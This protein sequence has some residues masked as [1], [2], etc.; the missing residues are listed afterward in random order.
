MPNKLETFSGMQ[1]GEVTLPNRLV[2]APV[3]TAFASPTGEVV[4]KHLAY[5]RR[6]AEGGV[7][8]IIV[9]PM[10]IDPLGKEHPKQLGIAS[11]KHIDGLKELVASIH[12]GGAVAIA[13]LNHGGRAANPKAIGCEAEAPSDVICPS[14]GVKPGVMS[15]ERIKEL[16]QVFAGAVERAVEAGFDIVEIQFGLGYLISQFISPQTNKRQDEYGGV[17][18]N[19]LR[20]GKEVLESVFN[21]PG[22][23]VPIIA[24]ISATV[25]GNPVELE[26]AIQL[27]KWLE[28]SGVSALHVASGSV[29]DSP[30]WYFQHMRLPGGKNLEW[31]AQIKENVS[32]PVIVAGRMGDPTLIRESLGNGLIDGI[33]LGRP[34]I[35]DPD[36]PDKIKNGKDDDVLLCGAC[37]QGCMAKVKSGEGISCILNPETGREGELI[38]RASIAKKVLI[39]GGGPAGM[40][41]A[42][43]AQR[44]GHNAVLFD[45]N[46]LGGR[47]NLAVIPP[48]KEEMSKPLTSMIN[49]VRKTGIDLRLGHRA[50]AMDIVEENPDCVVLATGAAPANPNISGL[51]GYVTCDELLL[52]NR[53]TGKNVLVIGGG[54]V[55]LETAE[56]L[57][58]KQHTVTVVELLD[59]VAGDMEKITAK[60]L[61]NNLKSYGVR[62][63]TETKIARFEGG[64]AFIEGDKGEY[65]LGEFDTIVVATGSKP[66]N[67]LEG[68]IRKTGLNVYL[69]GD[70]KNPS[71]IID[72]VTDG[73]NLGCQI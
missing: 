6:R 69:I 55:G 10:F 2:M 65:L 8:S 15:T 63:L 22:L 5:Y 72:A 68:E 19:R 13:H 67:E 42:L 39:V 57:A 26:D 48:G 51:E 70:A 25:T 56:M 20:F 45:D 28:A 60:L 30:P 53:E 61:L 58:K 27:A 44:R 12:E 11:Y 50:T 32:I 62:L 54:M 73:F 4:H 66:V 52:K 40:Q 38:P 46:G 24:R 1:I 49:R 29:C 47:F 71:N 36:L 43:T 3:K 35:A 34:L 23:R 59:E 21:V 16:V 17:L 64:K 9:E 31:A 7:G 33:A 18:E 41:V 37:L 14:K